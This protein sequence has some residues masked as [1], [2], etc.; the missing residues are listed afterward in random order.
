MEEGVRV[1]AREKF[2]VRATG[3]R[4]VTPPMSDDERLAIDRLIELATWVLWMHRTRYKSPPDSIETIARE[5]GTSPAVVEHGIA[6]ARRILAER[7]AAALTPAGRE[8]MARHA[9]ECP[10]CLELLRASSSSQGGA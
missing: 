5:L 7:K 8:R 10:E 2:R 6:E 3:G 1:D 9:R 4:V